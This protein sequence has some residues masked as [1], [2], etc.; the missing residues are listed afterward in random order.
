MVKIT[1]LMLI[2]III[3]SFGLFVI[4][5]ASFTHY[6]R[7]API[8]APIVN[9]GTGLAFPGASFGDGYAIFSGPDTS[10]VM[11]PSY[12]FEIS[13]FGNAAGS[14]IFIGGFFVASGPINFTITSLL[15]GEPL[16]Y[17]VENS[18][19]AA[20][21]TPNMYFPWFYKIEWENSNSQSLII[22]GKNLAFDP[23]SSI[24]GSPNPNLVFALG[25]AALGLLVLGVSFFGQE[26]ENK[27]F[28]SSESR[29][30]LFGILDASLTTWKAVFSEVTLPFAILIALQ[31]IIISIARN[32]YQLVNF[33]LFSL[34]NPFYSSL[35]RNDL[36]LQITLFSL[37]IM[38][39]LIALFSLLLLLTAEGMIIK[40]AYDHLT[41]N[42]TTLKESLKTA[43]KYSG[44]LLGALTLLF[45]ILIAGLAVFIIPGIY[46]AVILSLIFPAIIIEGIAIDKAIKRSIELTRGKKLDTF[47]LLIIGGMIAILTLI[48]A[49]LVAFKVAPTIPTIITPANY[50]SIS[51][52][53]FV[54]TLPPIIGFSLI[55]GTITSTTIPL[56]MII[57]TVWYHHLKK[58]KI[59]SPPENK[60]SQ[61]PKR[62]N[63][64]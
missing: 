50:F 26:K 49:Y 51:S 14:S 40:Y 32:V 47:K 36:L 55:I 7:Q 34:I 28:K 8:K 44:K 24:F 2:G 53:T 18:R 46:L 63:Q 9:V 64:K 21:I 31:V 38:Y 11:F 41:E 5:G 45:L 58:Q 52:T 42:K 6:T 1:R 27:K 29:N 54:Y 16:I 33:E 10:Q 62:T 60:K 48:L 61:K 43:T 13:L 17:R 35:H 15:P 30:G 57:I 20:F 37:P 4:A 3:I 12:S 23:I 39:Y 59:Q 19:V 25:V 22:V 56:S